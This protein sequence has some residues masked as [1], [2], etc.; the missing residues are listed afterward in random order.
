VS[1]KERILQAMTRSDFIRRTY[2]VVRGIPVLGV[3]MQKLVHS[4]MPMGTRMWVRIPEGLGKDLWMFADLRFEPGYMN[5]DHEPWIQGLLESELRQGNCYFDVGAHSGFFC[6][7]ASRFVGPS[8]NIVAFEPDPDNVAALRANMAKNCITQVAVEESAVWSSVGQVTFERAPDHSNRT[9]GR[10]TASLDPAIV[11]ISVP[12]VRLD[13]MVFRK[14]YPVPHLIKMDIEGAEWEALQGARRLLKEAKPKLLCEVHQPS[15][16]AR[17][18]DY[19]KQFGYAVEGW[20][21]LHPHYA[22]YTQVYLWAVPL[23]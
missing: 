14:G 3:R 5:G 10:I 15:D 6:L 7:I 4:A 22:D 16:M 20:E 2:G 13:D 21:P 9:Q 17:I 18:S 12:S 11:H 8:G 23:H 19:L 1:A